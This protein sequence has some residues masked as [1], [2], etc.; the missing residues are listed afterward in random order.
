MSKGSFK[1]KK[2]HFIGIGGAGM[3]GLAMFFLCQGYSVQGS[4]VEKTKVTDR[5]EQSGIRVYEDHSPESIKD[6]SCV[7][8]SSCIKE[9]NV[10]LKE[11]RKRNI[12]IYRR[13]EALNFLVKSKD[14][15]AVSGAHGKTTVTTL[16]SY[17]LVEG[18]LDPTVLIGADVDFLKGNVR[19]GKSNLVVTEADESDGSFLLVN[20][21]YSVATNI[22][23]EHMDFYDTMDDVIAS[24]KVFI[25]NT[26]T[27]GCAFVCADDKLLQDIAKATSKKLITYGLSQ[28]ADYRAERI[29]LLGLDGS[30]FDLVVKGKFI[31]RIYIPLIGMHNIVNSLGAIA[32]ARQLGMP[33]SIIK[34]AIR[35]FK[36]IDRR[37]NITHLK[38]DILLIDDY[39]HH[40]TE[41]KATLEILESQKRR[42]VAVFQPHRYSRTKH[43]REEFGRAFD[44]VNHLVIT[45]IYSAY[46]NPIQ[47]VSAKD[48]RESVKRNAHKDVYF[49]PRHDIIKHLKEILR[50]KDIVCILGAGDIGE[51]PEKLIQALSN[52]I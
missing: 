41:I 28:D 2:I 32:V 22:D 3:S 17:L 12:P 34:S 40:P 18:D 4:D 9:D 24:Y 16:I 50:P 43:L 31:D 38:R 27:E 39:A 1:R 14:L 35:N 19:C 26:R 21:L 37:F 49:V 48:I 30:E 25:E 44:T 36:G 45:D 47:D 15:V 52:E 51:L 10:E 5:L 11:A 33:A 23:K 29:E 20:P 46:E 7:V 6:S 42:I 13:M 8:Y